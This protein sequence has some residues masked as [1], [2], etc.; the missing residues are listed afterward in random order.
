MSLS[1][2]VFQV[3]NAHPVP[4]TP[5]SMSFS[6][7]KPVILLCSAMDDIAARGSLPGVVSMSLGGS[8]S[9]AEDDSALALIGAGY[10]VITSAG[11]DNADAC[12]Y[13]PARVPE[14]CQRQS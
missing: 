7:L 8:A 14:V 11:N 12:N 6:L 10:S 5:T 13:S 2:F 9:Q 1:G 3:E 4:L